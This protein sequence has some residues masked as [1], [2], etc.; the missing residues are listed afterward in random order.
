MRDRGDLVFWVI[1]AILLLI[2]LFGVDL[3]SLND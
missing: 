3:V 1:A 2:L